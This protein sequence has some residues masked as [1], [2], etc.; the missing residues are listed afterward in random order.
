MNE[1]NPDS[2]VLESPQ[3]MFQGKT[4]P[5]ST[6]I[7]PTRSWWRFTSTQ[8]R[9]FPSIRHSWVQYY[10]SLVGTENS[11]VCVLYTFAVNGRDWIFEAWFIQI[12][13]ENWWTWLM[14]ADTFEKF[15]LTM[16]R[17]TKKKENFLSEPWVAY[18]FDNFPQPIRPSAPSFFFPFTFN[19]KAK[20]PVSFRL[21]PR[22][23]RS[24]VPPLK[25][26]SLSV[27][28]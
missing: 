7:C 23:A 18:F 12:I 9:G 4:F 22:D 3:C 17:L 28:Q 14:R 2:T 16:V 15:D 26:P 5:H 19:T 11:D 10:C 8:V 27:S 25:Q 24:R 20:G 21:Q 1:R 13:Q 6:L